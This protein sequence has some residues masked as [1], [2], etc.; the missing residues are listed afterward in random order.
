[1]TSIAK[2]IRF[3]TNFSAEIDVREILVR[4][5]AAYGATLPFGPLPANDRFPHPKPTQARVPNVRFFPVVAEERH[6][7]STRGNRGQ[8]P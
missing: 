5:M 7:H 4:E 6:Q 1:M 2:S 8:N 3:S